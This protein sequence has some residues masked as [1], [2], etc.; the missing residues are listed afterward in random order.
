MTVNIK[1]ERRTRRKRRVRKNI[2]GTPERPRLTVF[3][4]LR[5]IYAQLIDDTTGKTLT[6]ASTMSK[7][8]KGSFGY[9]GNIKAASEVGKLLGERALAK[10]IKELRFDR[11][12]FRYHGRV[13]ALAE[14]VR[15]AG[16]KV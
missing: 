5:H 16:L 13:K 4:S 10:G 6:E 2:Y 12:G 7:D 1:V 3:R 9:G 14:A 8:L 11:N 15:E